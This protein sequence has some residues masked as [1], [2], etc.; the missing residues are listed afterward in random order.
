MFGLLAVNGWHN[1]V[2]MTIGALLLIA[3][4]GAARLAALFIGVL[5]L[6][7]AALGF[8]ATGGDGIDFVASN[9]VLIDLVP[10]NDEDNVLH[11]IL[12]VTG[13]IAALATPKGA[14]ARGH[15]LGRSAATEAGCGADRPPR[16]R[17]SGGVCGEPRPAAALRWPGR[18][19]RLR[20]RA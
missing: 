1:L 8:I 6:V 10:V 13:V 17:R 12:G 9:G 19:Q 16:R 3:A 7:L 4:G 5:Y 11:I 18:P 14:A 15:G 2:H 20:P